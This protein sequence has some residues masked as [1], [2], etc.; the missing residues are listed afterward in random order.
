MIA[1]PSVETPSDN[2]PNMPKQ[3]NQ[4]KWGTNTAMFSYSDE[5]YE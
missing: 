1:N 5:G 3:W 2:N 4:G